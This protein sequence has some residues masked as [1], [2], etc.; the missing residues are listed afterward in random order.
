MTDV[1]S[2]LDETL[3]CSVSVFTHVIDVG[4]IHLNESITRLKAAEFCWRSLVH[5]ADIVQV[6]SLI[7]V[8]IES[9]AIV[10]LPFAQETESGDKVLKIGS[11]ERILFTVVLTF[12][13]YDLGWHSGIKTMA[14]SI[15]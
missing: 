12:C 6:I 8:Q 13:T 7:S 9:I 11:N 1:S 2:V 5:F 14:K 4:S 10:V 3:N 15:S